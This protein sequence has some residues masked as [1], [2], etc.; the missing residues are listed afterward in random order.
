MKGRLLTRVLPLVLVESLLASLGL[1]A[2]AAGPASAA[3]VTITVTTTADNT[4]CNGG[5]CSLRGAVNLADADVAATPTN[6]VVINIPAGTYN[7]TN[8]ELD[9][10]GTNGNITLNGTSGNP[11]TVVINQTTKSGQ[12]GPNQI[13]NNIVALVAFKLSNSTIVTGQS[14][15]FQNLTISGGVDTRTGGGGGGGGFGGGGIQD[16]GGTGNALTI[17]NCVFSGNKSL[18]D[19]SGGGG[20]FQGAG[21]LTVSNST[22]TGNT[23]ASGFGGGIGYSDTGLAAGDVSITNSTF[24]NNTVTA[25]AGSSDAGGGAM[26]GGATITQHATVS[27]STFTGNSAGAD[28]GGLYIAGEL[29][30]SV[31]TSQFVN[32]TAGTVVQGKGGGVFMTSSNPTPSQGSGS[33]TLSTFTGNTASNSGVGGAIVN[34]I[35]PTVV[36]HNRIVGNTATTGS[37]VA[38]DV[39][40]GSVNANDNW[41]GQNS[42]PGAGTLGASGGGTTPT[43]TSWLQLRNIASPATVLPGGT[44][45]FTA[46]LLGRNT[47]GPLASGTLNGLASFPTPTG[48]FSTPVDVTLGTA[49]AQFVNGV[50]TAGV[51]AG[52][53]LGSPAG[54]LNATADSQ[55]I[56][57]DL[58]IKANSSTAIATSPTTS[59]FGQPVTFTAT[60]TSLT[61][62]TTPAVPQGGTVTF[63]VDGVSAGTANVSNGSASIM[64]AAMS[65]GMHTVN[66]SYGGD[67]DFNSSIGG[68]T[69]QTVNKANTSVMVTSSLN[70]SVF[71][72][73]VMFTATISAVAPGA[74]TPAGTGTVQFK[75]NV[76][77]L[78]AAVTPVGGVATFSTSSL[79]PGSY[80]ITAVYA[81]DGNFNGSTGTLS[82]PQV[83]NPEPP[84]IM[85]SFGTTTVPLNGTTSLSFAITNPVGNGSAPGIAFTDSLPSGLVVSTPNAL[86]NTCGGTVT[87]TSGAGS[88]S[89]TGGTLADGGSCNLSVNVTATTAGPQNN[90]VTVSS[91][92]GGTGNTSM[93]SVTVVAPPTVSKSFL[94]TTVAINGNSVLSFTI[95]N[96]NASQT[97]SG[98]ALTDPLPAGVQ[99]AATPGVTKNCGTGSV[100]ATA[101]SSTITLTGGTIAGGTLFPY[102]TLFR[103]PRPSQIA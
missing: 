35:G 75:A 2:F 34:D 71:T 81:G 68:G 95:G 93:A 22:F 101:G 62:G 12:T 28:G 89:L 53:T 98:V 8:G 32:N 91:T 24:T 74:G 7:L 43:A 97:L 19:G 64:D 25:P 13:V 4:T 82:S 42:G 23:S 46:D 70:P 85:K 102:T 38:E 9:I 63:T 5:T 15:T 30:T 27:G 103:S 29:S 33:I 55:T 11:A 57:G 72:Q 44:S 36:A 39:N 86:S 88:V 77:N 66:A 76:T 14:T 20:I 67:G 48:V 79:S 21:S 10:F 18:A 1:I 90:S 49:S 54:H 6:P 56:T 87:A 31:T 59:V 52:F 37:G 92:G 83:V 51:T 73:S 65:V 94:P 60:L 45:T 80:T 40:S 41:W 61:A 99:V 3:T 50:A 26:I 17:T 47:G 96:P 84:T 100:T 78:G 58:N 16:D 69:S